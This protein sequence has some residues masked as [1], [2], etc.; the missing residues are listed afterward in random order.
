MKKNICI[1]ILSIGLIISLTYIFTTINA[2]SVPVSTYVD[3]DGILARISLNFRNATIGG[4]AVNRYSENIALLAR[5]MLLIER[6]D[7][8]D[9]FTLYMAGNHL[10]FL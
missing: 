9:G 10:L 5:L 1:V 4:E 3:Y 7:Y 8:T 2:P 6:F